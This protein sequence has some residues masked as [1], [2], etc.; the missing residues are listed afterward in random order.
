MPAFGLEKYKQIAVKAAELQC[1]MRFKHLTRLH[2]DTKQELW[3][4]LDEDTK[5]GLKKLGGCYTGPVRYH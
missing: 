1:P 2:K 4:L 3:A 5:A